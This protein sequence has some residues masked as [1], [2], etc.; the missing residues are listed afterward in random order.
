[1]R[2]AGI[3]GLTGRSAF[4]R[5]KNLATAED[6]VNRKFATDDRDRLWVTDIT[7]HRTREGK[8]Y[9]CAVL[10]TYSRRVVGWAIDSAQTATL[11]TNALSMAIDNRQPD[12]TI[13]HSDQFTSWL[14]TQRIRDAGLTPSM[15]SIGDWLLTGL[16]ADA[17]RTPRPQ[18]LEHPCRA[19]YRRSLSSSRS[20]TTAS[21]DTHRLACSHQSSSRTDRP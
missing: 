9:C 20:S 15:G 2:R 14:F 13:I 11:V 8:L 21:G 7:K 17:G 5:V 18:A 3:Q 19:G 12:G 4:K 10:D 16:V 6:L 1:M